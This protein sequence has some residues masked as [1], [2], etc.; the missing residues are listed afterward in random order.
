MK[1]SIFP[2]LLGLIILIIDITYI[3]IPGTDFSKSE[4]RLLS[5]FGT[6]AGSSFSDNGF[7]DSLEQTLKDQFPLRDRII[8]VVSEMRSFFSGAVMSITSKNR[9]GSINA[10]AV[11]EQTPDSVRGSDGN[12]AESDADTL[13]I[14]KPEFE[15]DPGTFKLKPVGDNYYLIK[16]TRM[17]IPF[18]VTEKSHS[19]EELRRK[20][21]QIN[22]LA[23]SYPD[24]KVFLYYI[25]SPNELSWFNKTYGIQAF[26]YGDYFLP[27]LSGNITSGRSRITDLEDLENSFFMADHHLNHKGAYNVYAQV[28]DMFAGYFPI[29]PLM[30]PTAELEFP[31]LEWYGSYM[32]VAAVDKYSEDFRAYEYDFGEY[33]AYYGSEKIEIGLFEEYKAGS[34]S[35]DPYA[36]HYMEYYGYEDNV[37]K[38]IFPGNTRNLLIIGDSNTRSIRRVISSHFHTTVF[39]DYRAFTGDFKTDF[40]LD[41]CIENEKI[42]TILFIARRETFEHGGFNLKG[43]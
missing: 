33:E 32:R 30:V 12:S 2:V 37:V 6:T 40:D 19:K 14:S 9:S 27:L 34:F 8:G 29:S 18:P 38:M 13:E 1:K 24:I 20:A 31:G 25:Q 42:D 41:L 17:I 11:N 39:V 43:Y 36:E 10:G 26:D 22:N 3:V 28:Y 35:R 21:D 7:Q 15:Y 16:G 4:N 23:N 5:T